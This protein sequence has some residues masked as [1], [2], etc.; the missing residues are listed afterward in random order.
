MV[1]PKSVRAL[2]A[3]IVTVVLTIPTMDCATCPI[4][5]RLALL[6]VKGVVKANV[7]YEKRTARVTYDDSQTAL[8]ALTK[9]TQDVGYPSFRADP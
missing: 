8:G 6:R 3:T 7:S 4:T 9:A 2:A 5:I 1:L